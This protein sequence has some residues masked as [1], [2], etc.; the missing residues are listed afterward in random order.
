M[1]SIANAVV[2][3]LL[4]TIIA[5]NAETGAPKKGPESKFVQG[6]FS[7][8]R[9]ERVIEELARKRQDSN[10][11]VL[12]RTQLSTIV[13]AES[14]NEFA[15]LKRYSLMLLNALSQKEEEL[16]IKRAYIR[17]D[18]SD[19]E[20]RRVS[21]WRANVKADLATYKMYGPYRD[22]A[23]YLVPTGMMVR[24]GQILVDFT[25]NRTGQVMLQLPSTAAPRATQN[26]G[27]LD[28]EPNSQPDLKALQGLI[29]RKFPG[30]PA[31][32]SI[33]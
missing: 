3:G 33:H 31:P 19:V 18:G 4:I 27:D 30:F 32:K 11:A 7:Q 23:F 5:A 20:L 16:P 21:N 6:S 2:A 14:A 8:E 10:Q 15:A 28:P 1:Q 12:Q 25:M 17:A 13:Y 24:D 29:Q 26:F 9:I 22:D